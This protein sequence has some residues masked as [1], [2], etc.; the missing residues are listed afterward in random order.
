MATDA[1]YQVPSFM[2]ESPR[3]MYVE[4]GKYSLFTLRHL[5]CVSWGYIRVKI[6]DLQ[7]TKRFFFVTDS[8]FIIRKLCQS[9]IQF[10][11]TTRVC[12][13]TLAMTVTIFVLFE[14]I[15]FTIQDWELHSSPI[16]QWLFHGIK[17]FPK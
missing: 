7:Q 6:F 4:S 5:P 16:Y 1:V 14:G 8:N 15:S 9:P 13:Q 10:V 12:L 17:V 2:C 3:Y 11:V